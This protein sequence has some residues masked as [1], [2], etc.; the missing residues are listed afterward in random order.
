MD[1]PTIVQSLKNRQNELNSQ[2]TT[3]E[4]EINLLNSPLDK[5][6]REISQLN[7][8]IGRASIRLNKKYLLTFTEQHDLQKDIKNKQQTL[9]QLQ[10]QQEKIYTPQLKAQLSQLT[11]THSRLVSDLRSTEE[12][13]TQELHKLR[14]QKYEHRKTLPIDLHRWIS[15]NKNFYNNE[16]RFSCHQVANLADK[17]LNRILSQ[18]ELITGTKLVPG[19]KLSQHYRRKFSKSRVS[20]YSRSTYLVPANSPFLKKKNDKGK[21]N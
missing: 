7:S 10:Q 8:Y 15:R 4:Q 19:S 3:T 11:D 14:L 13:L 2:I 9:Q 6:N 18:I 12:S 21:E 20:Q 1:I 5:L 17:R 16:I